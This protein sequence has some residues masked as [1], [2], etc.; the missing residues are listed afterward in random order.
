[1]TDRNNSERPFRVGYGKP[2]KHTQFAKG[3][4]GNP[5]GRGKGGRNF[6]T[7][8]E[9]ELNARVPITENGTRKKV[10][11]RKGVAKRLVN[12]AL[13]D[14]K[15]IPTLL[16]QVRLQEE[17]S[18]VESGP[19]VLCRPEDQLVMADIIRRIREAEIGPT[20]SPEKPAEPTAGNS[21]PNVGGTV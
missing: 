12:A 1:M 11:K 14:F 6:T 8:I 13:A 15:A 17:R 16:N 2:P 3:K 21:D 7:E 5:K 10:T 19:E 9:E 18:N 20:D 4:S